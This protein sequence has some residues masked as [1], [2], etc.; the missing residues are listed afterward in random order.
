MSM[1]MSGLMVRRPDVVVLDAL[2]FHGLEQA[3]L[4]LHLFFQNLDEPA[5]V[6]H[7]RAHLLDLVFEVGDMRLQFFKPPGGF[8]CHERILPGDGREVEAVN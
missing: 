5:L 1:R 4:P 2:H 7:H 8:I 3:R 6:G